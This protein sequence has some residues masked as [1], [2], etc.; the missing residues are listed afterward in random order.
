MSII[1]NLIF[2][3]L[4]CYRCRK[5]WKIFQENDKIFA[6]EEKKNLKSPYHEVSST[7]SADYATTT[8]PAKFNINVNSTKKLLFENQNDFCD[9]NNKTCPGYL[10]PC[11]LCR[12]NE[13]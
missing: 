13:Y 8:I 10:F 2:R 6:T 1:F 7:T 4:L 5:I 11:E 9:Y 12:S 3:T